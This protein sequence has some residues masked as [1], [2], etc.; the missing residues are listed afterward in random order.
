VRIVGDAGFVAAAVARCGGMIAADNEA[1]AVI[2]IGQAADFTPLSAGLALR[3]GEEIA[4]GCD[5]VGRPVLHVPDL[6]DC[7]M[8]A[9]LVLVPPLMRQLT[10]AT[11]DAAPASR[12]TLTR[13]ISSHIGMAEIVLFTVEN[14]QATPI[15]VGDLPLSAIARADAWALVPPEAEG[16]AA[17]DV[18]GVNALW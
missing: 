13:R 5:G 6:P 4:L 3:P 14:D 8:A 17:G 7:L 18:I 16:H 9:A 11:H 2:V 15:A 12:V 1:D 10:G